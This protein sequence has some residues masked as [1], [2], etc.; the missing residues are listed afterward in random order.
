MKGKRKM[1]KTYVKPEMTEEEVLTDF[2][3]E[4]LITSNVEGGGQGEGGGMADANERHSI[5][6]DNDAS[7][8]SLW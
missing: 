1:K 7:G 2:I 5:W 3:L 4:E 6:G 8:K